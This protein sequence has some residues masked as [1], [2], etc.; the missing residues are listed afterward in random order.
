LPAEECD[1]NTALFAHTL[2]PCLSGVAFGLPV[3]YN[4]L[5]SEPIALVNYYL[6]FGLPVLSW[7]CILTVNEAASNETR[8]KHCRNMSEILVISPS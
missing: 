5:P 1:L 3:I 6:R 7:G 8:V 4:Y 2:P